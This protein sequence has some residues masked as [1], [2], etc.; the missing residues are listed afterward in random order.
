M[1]ELLLPEL[2]NQQ[3]E[4]E[5]RTNKPI[6]R[7]AIVVSELGIIPGSKRELSTALSAI[8]HRD[9]P[10]G[11]AHFLNEVLLHQRKANT[12]DPIAALRKIIGET[13]AYAESA[14]GE[15]GMLGLLHDELT[16]PNLHIFQTAGNTSLLRDWQDVATVKRAL[17]T[18]YNS[19]RTRQALE[20]SAMIDLDES[21]NSEDIKEYIDSERVG[22][23][24]SQ[25][26][27][28]GVEQTAR[29][30]FWRSQ[31]EQAQRHNAVAQLA[32]TALYRL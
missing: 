7:L 17:N 2:H 13:K 15:I 1:S 12:D 24:R 31:L 26:R 30:E 11:Y 22:S 9:N 25:V 19:H 6:D 23:L 14:K 16:D 18:T 20:E 27:R 21:P 5:V 3:V 10:G 28:T 8:E 32:R 29:L 4:V